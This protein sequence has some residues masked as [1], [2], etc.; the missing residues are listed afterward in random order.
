MPSV[1]RQRLTPFSTHTRIVSTFPFIIAMWRGVNPQLSSWSRLSC[2]A[3]AITG[4]SRPYMRVVV[5]FVV[6]VDLFGEQLGLVALREIVEAEGNGD[7]HLLV[8]FAI[9]LQYVGIL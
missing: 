9:L 7:V 3:Y 8:F 2:T 5:Q 1:L 4:S 6:F